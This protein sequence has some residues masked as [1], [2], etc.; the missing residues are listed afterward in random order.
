MQFPKFMVENVIDITPRAF[1]G[2]MKTK[3]Q[4]DL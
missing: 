1:F 4:K 2:N 3:I